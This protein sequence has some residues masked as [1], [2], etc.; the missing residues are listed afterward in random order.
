M[1]PTHS[2]DNALR[3]G[4]LRTM[5]YASQVAS[6]SPEKTR[7]EY[8]QNGRRQ[9]EE[10][11]SQYLARQKVIGKEAARRELLT[12]FANSQR[13]GNGTRANLSMPL[14]SGAATRSGTD[15]PLSP[16]SSDTFHPET[17]RNNNLN[18]AASGTATHSEAALPPNANGGDTATARTPVA[19]NMIEP[20]SGAAAKAAVAR[21]MTADEIGLQ[22]QPTYRSAETQT[23]SERVNRN[24][25]RI[26]D[27]GRQG[28]A[29]SRQERSSPAQKDEEL[30]FF[31]NM[32]AC[33]SGSRN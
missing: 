13:F 21:G 27:Q 14:S 7:I 25:E 20:N 16:S 11:T 5:E 1:P 8:Q 15:T 10:L 17:P 12:S 30:G 23:P 32:W 33:C 24:L 29:H 26:S 22:E 6:M 4:K 19:E 2:L 18:S 9:F 3:A 31:A 28:R